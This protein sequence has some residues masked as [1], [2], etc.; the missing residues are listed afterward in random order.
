MSKNKVTTTFLYSLAVISIIGFL[1][2]IGQT[3]FKFDFITTNTSSLILIVLGFGLAV[4]GQIRRWKDMPKNGISSNELSHVVT[5]IIGLMA[6]VVG[7]VGL[8]GI[9]GDT[10]MATQGIISVIAIFIIILET[11]IVK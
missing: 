8:L 9:T 10:L 3:W 6:I 1:G 4:E 2:I 5:G 11:F 7:L